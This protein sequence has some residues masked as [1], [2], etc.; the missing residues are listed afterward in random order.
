M[1]KCLNPNC[2]KLVNNKFCGTRCQNIYQNPIKAEKLRA[3][4][5]EKEKRRLEEIHICEQCNIEFQLG[6]SNVPNGS[7][8]FC[9]HVCGGRFR[10]N[11]NKEER[12]K[13]AVETRKINAEKKPKINKKCI[14]KECNNIFIARKLSQK[15]CSKSCSA[16]SRIYS[17]NTRKKLRISAANRVLR[18]KNEITFYELCVKQ[19]NNVEHNKP[20]FNG[21]DA[22]VIIHDIKVAV[23][24]N[25]PWH[26]KPI[27]NSKLKQTQNRD[28]LKLIEIQ[29]YGYEPYII[30]DEGSY[31]LKFV[32]KQFEI[33]I[34]K[35][36]NVA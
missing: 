17:E 18:S 27:A 29:K 19:F 8:R 26:Y 14:A 15:Y 13:K 3:K 35:Y 20:I 1:N 7:G 30:K 21:W 2:E 28:K 16:K 4:R 5:Y 22:D 11:L 36:A 31:N 9:S 6:K 32:E 12:I 33:F 24:W 10:S 25:G 23:L 34:S